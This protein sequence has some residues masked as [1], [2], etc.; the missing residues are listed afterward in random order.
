MAA[1]ADCD[2]PDSP[3]WRHRARD[4]IE[5]QRGRG[6]M[7]KLR[8]PARLHP[9]FVLAQHVALPKT[10]RVTN[11]FV[12]TSPA[13]K[14]WFSTNE[15]IDSVTSSDLRIDRRLFLNVVL[16]CIFCPRTVRRRAKPGQRGAG[17]SASAFRTNRPDGV[18]C[19]CRVSGARHNIE[20]KYDQ[21]HNSS[22]GSL[23]GKRIEHREDSFLRQAFAP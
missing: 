8:G 13:R 5:G 16:S 15:K 9:H 6:L 22:P 4:S 3:L 23:R 18:G 7:A 1:A 21:S 17:K 2:Q 12:T 11:E 10:A 14:E 19:R 20:R